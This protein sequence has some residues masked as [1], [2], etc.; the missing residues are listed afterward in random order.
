MSNLTV[1]KQGA[2]ILYRV[3][4]VQPHDKV[5]GHTRKVRPM[6]SQRQ[7]VSGI[8]MTKSTDCG[9]PKED[10]RQREQ[11]HGLEFAAHQGRQM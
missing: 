7:L 1:L 8:H 6:W 3:P 4:Q 10:T 9:V 2:N 5:R 11:L